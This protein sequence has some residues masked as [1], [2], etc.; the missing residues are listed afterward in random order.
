M[1][2]YEEIWQEK[3]IKPSTYTY[4][5]QPEKH[6]KDVRKMS[7]LYANFFFTLLT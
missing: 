6:N 4:I 1:F 7:L 2:I 3:T 5:Q